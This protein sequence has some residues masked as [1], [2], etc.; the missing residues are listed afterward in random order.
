MQATQKRKYTHLRV[1]NVETLLTTTLI[2]YILSFMEW[3]IIYLEFTTLNKNFKNL[4]Y[5][6]KL[7]L[8][9][10]KW[11]KQKFIIRDD[12]FTLTCASQLKHMRNVIWSS[13]VDMREDWVPHSSL[14]VDSLC[15]TP[16]KTNPHDV[17][18]E[19]DECDHSFKIDATTFAKL[20][21]KFKSMFPA[22]K[23]LKLLN[24]IYFGFKFLSA[25]NME[26]LQQ[27]RVTHWDTLEV[28]TVAE[29]YQNE[30]WTLIHVWR[31]QHLVLQFVL[32]SKR[33]TECGCFCFRRTDF[34]FVAMK[35][36]TLI[37][38]ED[39]EIPW[40]S[41]EPLVS[42]C[43][44]L[45]KL[46]LFG[47][48]AD[49]AGS[50]LWLPHV[51]YFIYV[52][53]DEP[54][55]ESIYGKMLTMLPNLE[56]LEWDVG[57]IDQGFV[58]MIHSMKCLDTLKL[59]NNRRKKEFEDVIEIK[60]LIHLDVE[61]NHIKLTSMFGYNPNVQNLRFFR[62]RTVLQEG[63]LPMFDV[64]FPSVTSYTLAGE[65]ML[66][67]MKRQRK[68][69][70]EVP[71]RKLQDL[72]LEFDFY[73]KKTYIREILFQVPS[74]FQSFFFYLPQIMEEGPNTKMKL[75]IEGQPRLKVVPWDKDKAGWVW[76]KRC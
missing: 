20:C 31:V 14:A 73:S 60:K 52:C 6:C 46:A 50:T 35:E 36:L 18:E 27:F 33:D 28:D 37:S 53:R 71:F 7:N 65:Y 5:T 47:Y 1:S 49:V 21:T 16:S 54:I 22:L 62:T 42:N 23:T 38:C 58:S 43:P 34:C 44:N 56:I 51:K 55:P 48:F 76:T 9:S 19:N 25:E 70:I 61:M 15:L 75:K 8:F 41:L 32:D 59:V 64:A 68:L 17:D 57:V 3:N 11:L 2:Q 24:G 26:F 69:V 74:S 45:L 67:S 12:L 40:V 72:R 10:D 66:S 39:I 30:I 4:I 29:I 13:L 63:F